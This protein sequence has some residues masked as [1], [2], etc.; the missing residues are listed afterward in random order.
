MPIGGDRFPREVKDI[1]RDNYRFLT[2][3]RSKQLTKKDPRTRISSWAQLD[4]LVYGSFN[5]L[6][7]AQLMRD[8]S[9]NKKKLIRELNT[10]RCHSL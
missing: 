8:T 3:L 2:D 5:V 4:D 9:D 6:G 7:K 10:L 1:K